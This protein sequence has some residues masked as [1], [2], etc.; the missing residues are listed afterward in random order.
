M[1]IG[2]DL[3]AARERAGL[4]IHDLSARTKIREHIIDA[5]ERDDFAHVPTGLL[6]RGFLRAYAQEVKLHP[7]TI[8]RRYRDDYEAA[9]LPAGMPL[10]SSRSEEEILGVPGRAPWLIAIG[11]LAVAM[12]V[13]FF[14]NRRP[15]PAASPAVVTLEEPAEYDAT[16]QPEARGSRELDAQVAR[17]TRLVDADL[18]GPLEVALQP[19]S[20][21]WVQATSDGRRVLYTLLQPGQRTLIQA[22]QGLILRIG[23]AGAVEYSI[24]GIRGRQLG[25]PGQV[26]EIQITRDNRATFLDPALP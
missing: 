5:L 8:V 19:T 3:R 25:A 13:V 23:D 16:S 17:Q 1:S 18:S 22:E 14:L 24:N 11:V 21:V 10:P 9:A 4:S 26:R 20:V 2:A 7:E 6:A 12:L 15:A